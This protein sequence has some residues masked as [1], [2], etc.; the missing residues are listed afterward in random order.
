LNGT[1]IFSEIRLHHRCH[2]TNISL[3]AVFIL[4]KFAKLKSFNQLKTKTDRL[5]YDSCWLSSTKVYKIERERKTCKSFLK[6]N[7]VIKGG[8]TWAGFITRVISSNMMRVSI[9]LCNPNWH[10]I[11]IIFVSI[12]LLNDLPRLMGLNESDSKDEERSFHP[13]RPSR[14][15]RSNFIRFGRSFFPTSNRWG[16]TVRRFSRTPSA[17]R[18]MM[19]LVDLPVSSSV[20]RR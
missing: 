15:L 8:R 4:F 2:A 19:S 11:Y 1:C 7:V 17:G 16:E 10:S 13:V 6:I 14:S 9:H 18:H 5:V 3:T 20:S 12:F